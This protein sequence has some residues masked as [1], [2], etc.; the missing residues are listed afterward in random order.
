MRWN[1]TKEFIYYF[2]FAVFFCYFIPL[3]SFVEAIRD[4]ITK[5]F[6]RQQN[7]KSN[8]V[9]GLIIKLFLFCSFVFFCHAIIIIVEFY[10]RKLPLFLQSKTIRV[11]LKKS[12]IYF[13]FDVSFWFVVIWINISLIKMIEKNILLRFFFLFL[14]L[15]GLGYK[16]YK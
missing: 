3:A 4:K 15:F 5:K 8:K 12:F 1:E 7:K 6:I 9:E 16:Q 14:F 10:S 13:Y 2:L 11:F